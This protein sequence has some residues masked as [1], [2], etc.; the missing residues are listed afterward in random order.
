[1]LGLTATPD[2]AD[3]ADVLG[4]FDS[5]GHNLVLDPNS[6]SANTDFTDPLNHDILGVDPKLGALADNG[7]P[8]RTHALLAGSLAIDHGT[9]NGAPGVDQRG[10]SR[11][12]DG[13]HNGSKIVDIGAFEL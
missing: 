7:G 6:F 11:V 10:L 4:L 5:L 1:M 8:T 9:N 13:D 3:A 12:K 2:R